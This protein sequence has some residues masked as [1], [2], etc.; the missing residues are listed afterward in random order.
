MS[1][2]DNAIIVLSTDPDPENRSEPSPGDLSLRAS[3]SVQPQYT[4]VPS[5][6]ASSANPPMSNVPKPTARIIVPTWQKAT[7]EDDDKEEAR[8]EQMLE[9]LYGVMAKGA[10]RNRSRQNNEVS[11][12][13][14]RESITG[15]R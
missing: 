11:L 15:Q 12:R 5:N 10:G 6:L 1:F 14:A 13:T 9:R 8:V 7:S 3:G 4:G 2:P